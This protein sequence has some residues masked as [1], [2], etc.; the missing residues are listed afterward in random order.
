MKQFLFNIFSSPYTSVK[1]HLCQ[2]KEARLTTILADGK[3]NL[4]FLRHRGIILELVSS[5]FP[6]KDKLHITYCFITAQR[7][8]DSTDRRKFDI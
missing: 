8:H 7:R 6:Y 1:N 3:Q 4:L 2:I 5:D